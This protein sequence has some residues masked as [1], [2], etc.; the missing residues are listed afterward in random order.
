MV[1]SPTDED[2]IKNLPPIELCMAKSK[3]KANSVFN[4]SPGAIVI[5]CDTVVDCNGIL[6]EKPLSEDE[7]KTF[8]R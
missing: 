4:I 2:E 7:A 3:L 1:A 6:L 5:G 8:M